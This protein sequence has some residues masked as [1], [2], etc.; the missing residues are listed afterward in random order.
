MSEELNHHNDATG[1]VESARRATGDAPY[2]GDINEIDQILRKLTADVTGRYAAVGRREIGAED[3]ALSDRAECHRLAE[4]FD[5]QDNGYVVIEHW[6]GE[7]LATHIRGRMGEVVQPHDDDEQIIAQAF[8]VFV[9]RIYGA[10]GAMAADPDEVEQAE[11]A[12]T[13]DEN[14]R[15]FTWLLAGIESNE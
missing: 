1:L 2:L 14:I 5:G 8:G 13:L 9:H 10:I 12:E 3:A 11:L 7:G 15:S 4:V 6:N